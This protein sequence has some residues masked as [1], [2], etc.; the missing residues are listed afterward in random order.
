MKITDTLSIS[1]Q[2]I[3]GN[4]L[5]AVITALIISIGIMALVGILTAVDGIKLALDQNFAGMGANSF[6]IKN[7]GNNIQF[8]G[9]GKPSKRYRSITLGEARYFAS[10]FEFDATTSLSVNASFSS[11]VKHEGVKTDPN[12]MVMGGDEHYLKVA[13]YTIDA[14]RDFSAND[15]N[16]SG[17]VA[18]IGKDISTKLFKNKSPLGES[19]F[20]GGAK[21][22]V[23]GTLKEKGNSMGFGGDRIVIVPLKNAM[24]MFSKPN[25]SI[26]ITIMVND[27][28]QLDAAVDEANVLFRRVRQLPVYA[29]D[30][31]EIIKSDNLAEKSEDIT[32][33]VTMFAGAIAFITLL[34]AAVGLMNIMLVSV[35]ERT[36]EIGVRK[37]IGATRQV[38][39]RQFLFEA[40][41]ICQIGGMLGVIL[42]IGIGNAVSLLMNGGFIIPWLWIFTGLFICLVVGVVSGYYPAVK[43]SKLDAIEALRYE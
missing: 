37:A 31:F 38:I 41:L 17:N 19:V 12:I 10:Q 7:R 29:Q 14:G 11:T 33:V 18:I 26:V 28:Q 34:G 24:Q 5:R 42:G 6:S 21:Y 43:A 35:T 20:V 23:I 16:S 36:R 32:G 15:I 40:I 9:G 13:G 27:I 25:M 4:K 1:L 3:A 22:R 2:S 8:G 39:Q 30:N